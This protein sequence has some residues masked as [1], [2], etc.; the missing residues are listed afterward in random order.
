[1]RGLLRNGL[2]LTGRIIRHADWFGHSLAALLFWG[3]TDSVEL[4]AALEF[5]ETS[6]DANAV[7]RLAIGVGSFV[8][9]LVGFL[10]WAL[11]DGNVFVIGLSGFAVGLAAFSGVMYMPLWIA[12]LRRTRSLGDATALVGLLVLRLRLEP[13]LERAVRFTTRTDDGRLSRALAMHARQERGEPASGL[14][15]FAG[16]WRMHFRAL[17]RAAAQLATA[18]TVPP[19]RRER[20]LDRALSAVVDG[21]REELATFASGIR[22]PVTGIYAFGVLLPLA[23]VGVIPAA[24][25]AGIPVSLELIVGF[26]CL[27]LPAGLVAAGGWLLARR[28]VAF[29]PP[30]VTAAHPD[31]S[32]TLFRSLLVGLGSGIA[33]SAGVH[34]VGPG[35]M[36]PI[37]GI[38]LGVGLALWSWF[39]HVESVRSHVRAVEAGLPDALVRLGQHVAEGDAVERALDHAARE[40]TGAIA[41]V[42]RDAVEYGHTFR[43]DVRT[44]F[45]AP[46]GAL[47]TVP[48]PR[49]RRAAAL[50]GVAARAG[51]PAGDVILDLATH[52]EELDR[53]E[54]EARGRLADVTGTLSNTALLFAPLIGGATVALSDRIRSVDGGLASGFQGGLGGGIEPASASGHRESLESAGAV[55]ATG[56]LGLVIGV[57]VLLLATVLTVLATGLERGLD[58]ASIGYRVGYTLPIA[59]TTYLMAFWL[60]GAML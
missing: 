12:Q 8:G 54:A 42:L 57:Y 55:L 25:A 34:I 11:V 19:E 14:R 47:S 6:W 37:A 53:I 4:Q 50:L 7:V 15:S 22:T 40:S 31:A 38:G 49:F 60:A 59:A 51:R 46:D 35:W 9:F 41:P 43:V 18:P 24:P 52:L 27:L 13:S 16:A 30:P 5:I 36:R 29:P 56:D 10:G 48:S 20:T 26:Y 58:P 32:G 28:P 39:R 33:A 23:L 3:E 44:A 17:D 45:L 2:L 21:T 1:M